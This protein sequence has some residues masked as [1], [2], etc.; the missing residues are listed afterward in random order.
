MDH[1][2]DELMI[3]L[4]IYALCILEITHTA[5]TLYD[6]FTMLAL[7]TEGTSGFNPLGISCYLLPAISKCD[8]ALDHWTSTR[9]NPCNLVAFIAQCF[10]AFRIHRFSQRRWPA[11]AIA[12]VSLSPIKH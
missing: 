10:Y 7:Q 5:V 12:L 9:I 6:G 3:K 11:I 4:T 8:I 2:N 1:S